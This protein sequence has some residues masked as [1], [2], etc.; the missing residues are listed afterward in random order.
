M[1]KANWMRYAV[2]LFCCLMSHLVRADV[3]LVGNMNIGEQCG[4]CLYPSA[5]S[6]YFL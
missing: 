1:T 4:S 2:M 6:G 3:V 5:Y